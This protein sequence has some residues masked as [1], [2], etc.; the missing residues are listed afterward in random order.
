[1]TGSQ[2]IVVAAFVDLVLVAAF[3]L[4]GRTSHREPLGA[5]EFLVT[6]WPFAV[7]LAAGW[8][9]TRAWRAPFAIGRVG[10]PLWLI[11]VVV[12]LALRALTGQGVLVAFVVVS[13]IVLGAFL[14]GW[15]VLLEALE[16]RS[17]RPS[18]RRR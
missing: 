2:R 10:L 18:A 12:G 1:V 11:T 8:A 14:L 13:T 15:R 16:R 6:V 5:M 9:A 7:G 3:V 4:I 17:T